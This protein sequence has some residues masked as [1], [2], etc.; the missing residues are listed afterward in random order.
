MLEEYSLEEKRELLRISRIR[1]G[2]ETKVPREKA[3]D[4]IVE[5]GI[6]GCLLD[7]PCAEEDINNTI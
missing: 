7:K 6:F 3:T 1:I 5:R 2:I 4:S